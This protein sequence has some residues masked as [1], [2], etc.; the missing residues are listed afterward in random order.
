M[1]EYPFFKQKNKHEKILPARIHT[2]PSEFS[3]AE[4]AKNEDE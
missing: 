3:F 4:E 2:M 1:V